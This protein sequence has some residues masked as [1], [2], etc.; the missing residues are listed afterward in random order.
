MEE[1]DSLLRQLA[2][3]LERLSA[4]ARG[5]IL[6]F[7][8][9]F[10]LAVLGFWKTLFILICTLLGYVL[11]VRFFSSWDRFRESLDK[12]FPPGFFH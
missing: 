9:A 3:D 11:G 7:L 6:G 10:L 2:R 1:P 12:L 8:L 5:A 4:G